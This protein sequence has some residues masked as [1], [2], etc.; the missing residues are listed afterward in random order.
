MSRKKR[1]SSQSKRTETENEKTQRYLRSTFRPSELPQKLGE[2]EKSLLDMDDRIRVFQLYDELE[3]T[4]GYIPRKDMICIP[5][6]LPSADHEIA[7]ML[8]MRTPE[9]WVLPD[10]GMKHPNDGYK[11]PKDF[12]AS[13]SREIRVRAIQAHINPSCSDPDFPKGHVHWEGEATSR[14]HFGRFKCPQDIYDWGHDL[15]VKTHMA[16]SRD[17][18]RHEWEVRLNYIR[19]WMETKAAA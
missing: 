1:N 5:V 14:L 13:L 6:G 3:E 15:W 18:I 16:W 19:N 10:W 4:Q 17:R 9:R 8:E 11:S 7:H 2:F 12:F